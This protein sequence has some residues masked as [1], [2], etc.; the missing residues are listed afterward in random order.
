M[1]LTRPLI[2]KKQA[3][4]VERFVTSLEIIH[5]HLSLFIFFSAI[6][7]YSE[8]R[9]N[10]SLIAHYVIHYDAILHVIGDRYV[11]SPIIFT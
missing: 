8:S 6:F 7:V 2:K 5:A 3:S 4:H 1:E 9:I 10:V 11:A